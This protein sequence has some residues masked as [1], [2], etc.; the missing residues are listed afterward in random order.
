MRDDATGGLARA[1][2]QRGELR[3]VLGSRIDEAEDGRCSRRGPPPRGARR[4]APAR[5]ELGLAARGEHRVRLVLR[6]LDVRLVE[7]VDLEEGAGDGDRELPA[8]ELLRRARRDSRASARPPGDRC[9]RAARPVPAPV[10]CPASRWIPRSAARP[11]A[12]NPLA[13]SGMQ[14]LSLPAR[15]PSPSCRPSSRPGLPSTPWQASAISTAR[16]R[17]RSISTPIRAAGTMPKGESAEKRPPIVGSPASTP[18]KPRSRASCSRALPGS[19][20]AAKRLPFSPAQVQKYSR[21]ERVSI[22]EP[23][24]EETRRRSKKGRAGM[25]AGAR[26]SGESSRGPGSS[27]RRRRA[28]SPRAPGS[29]RPCPAARRSRRPRAPARRSRGVSRA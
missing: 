25:R 22:V 16:E 20:T 5:L 15:Q 7:G 24:F 11:R 21:C 17:N 10:P 12:R 28:A 3:V 4:R 18:R 13:C 2:G 27:S 26:P 14:T 19:V 9:R 23:D 1:L 29:S 6:L 8:E